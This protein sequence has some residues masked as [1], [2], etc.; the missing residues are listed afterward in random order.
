MTE[1]PKEQRSGEELN[2][3]TEKPHERKESSTGLDANDILE[4]HPTVGGESS[5]TVSVDEEIRRQRDHER[6]M[7]ARRLEHELRMQDLTSRQEV[8]LRERELEIYLGRRQQDL[9]EQNREMAR[10]L[11]REL[12]AREQELA[13]NYISIVKGEVVEKQL[14]TVHKSARGR[15]I[16]TFILLGI[17]VAVAAASVYAGR[18]VDNTIFWAVSGTIFFMASVGLIAFAA[19]GLGTFTQ[20]VE[21]IKMQLRSGGPVVGIGRLEVPA[22]DRVTDTA[23]E[24]N[25]DKAPPLPRPIGPTRR[26]S[27]ELRDDEIVDE[28]EP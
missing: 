23:R 4:Q 21:L 19:T 20:M 7:E 14:D 28:D 5:N 1:Q 16:H 15:E 18:L 27:D 12:R 13:S 9:Q 3:L 24:R 26:R 8:D 11:E 10:R 17:L 2:A 25:D 22:D 6:S